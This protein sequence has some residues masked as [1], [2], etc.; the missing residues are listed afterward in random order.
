MP[1]GLAL[2]FARNAAYIVF[3]RIWSILLW[4]ALTPFILHQL[5]PERFGVWS[6]LFL[7]S[8]YFLTFDLGL[9]P[10]VVKF[11][12]QYAMAGELD[13]LR[14]TLAGITRLYL[15]LG[16]LWVAAIVAIHPLLLAWLKITPPYR[17]EVRFAILV[18]A[19]VFAF[20]NLVS[21]GMGILN[22]LQRMGT[23]NAVLVGAS[24]PQI[25]ILVAGLKAGY[26]L[27]AVV[28]STAVYWVV[29]ALAILYALGKV[30]PSLSWPSVRLPKGGSPW[31]RFSST[32]QASNVI[33][34]AQQQVDKILLVIWA[35]VRAVTHFELGFRVANAVQSLPTLAL[36]PLLPTF[37]E[38]EASGDRDRFRR[39]SR[40]GT[41][42]LAAFAF[43]LASGAIPAAPLLIRAWV[44]PGYGTAAGLAQWLLAGL[45]LNL[46][47]GVAT[48]AGRA[49]GRPGLEILPGL[50]A[51]TVHVV[52]SAILIGRYGPL[53][54]GPA[55]FA[56][57]VVWAVLFLIRFSA[58][59]EI[60][61]GRMLAA[62]FAVP[63]LAVG[64]AIACGVFVVARWPEAWVTSRVAALA[65]AAAGGTAGAAVFALLSWILRR[66]PP[67]RG[68]AATEPA[69]GPIPS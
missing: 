52:A 5:G 65:G 53:G 47:T 28:A 36:I 25:V 67:L 2:R 24:L 21:V 56:A 20:A 42:L 11:T 14:D 39:L 10:S 58:A 60:P 6:L 9:G 44:G 37:A 18:S 66:I 7:L 57:M 29:A 30:A 16:A 49:A 4:V 3:G 32:I 13:R 23:Q 63:G 22:G 33:A 19:V 61:P 1:R 26:G 8:S 41:G 51:L 64:P 55:F 31:L 54:V 12:A 15:F 48:S 46:C 35:G 17:E 69:R 68:L 34:M 50:I 43:A 38:L 45:A 27:Y 40:R 62:A 59:F